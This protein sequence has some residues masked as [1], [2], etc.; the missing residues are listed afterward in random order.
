MTTVKTGNPLSTQF[1]EK[2]V[3]LRPTKRA[4]KEGY[5]GQS[6]LPFQSVDDYVVIWDAIKSEN[7]LAGIFALED[8]PIP[9]QD[10][11][12]DTFKSDVMHISAMRTV[13][14]KDIQGLRQPGEASVRYGTG[15]GADYFRRKNARKVAEVTT[16]SEDALDT[17][18]EYL[19]IHS[20]L[21]RI[22]WPPLDA[23]G[24]HIAAASLPV[25]WGDVKVNFPIPFL[26]ASGG[27]GSF[28]QAATTLASGI[29]GG[30]AAQGYAWNTDTGT[31]STSGNMIRDMEVIG[32]L[33]MERQGLT[34][35]R[36]EILCSRY[37]LAQSAFNT[38][39]LHWIMGN[40]NEKPDRNMVAV[41]EVKD[42]I[43]T[44]F[45]WSFKLYDAQ[46]TYVVQTAYGSATPT[47]NRVR[48]LPTNKVLIQP[49]PEMGDMGVMATAPAPGP[50]RQWRDGKYFWMKHLQEPPWVSEMGMGMYVWPLV[51]QTD[52]RFLLDAFA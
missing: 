34:P 5:V 30:L 24:A 35:D 45:G 33:M 44:K 26:A 41:G 38:N 19:S 13:G 36:M 37:I 52:T 17:M 29:T 16:W 9:G 32:Q 6:Y 18:V 7:P 14:P 47:V 21:G 23:S 43:S 46:W 22:V 31:G 8:K 28:S 10:L 49:R 2:V 27:L 1:M 42:F 4:I 3:E 11:D 15:W 48:F 50:A 12:F 39:M 51:F 20:L 40:Q 25:H